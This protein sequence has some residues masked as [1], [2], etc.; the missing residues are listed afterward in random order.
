MTGVRQPEGLSTATDIDHVYDYSE[1]QQL[2]MVGIDVSVEK[3]LATAFGTWYTG[4]LTWIKIL[5]DR[6]LATD[7]DNPSTWAE[8]EF[9][10]MPHVQDTSS[11]SIATGDGFGDEY[12]DTMRD[13]MQQVADSGNDRSLVTD[14]DNSVYWSRGQFYR[15]QGV[16]DTSTKSMATIDEF[17]NVYVE[18]IRNLMQRVE[19]V[20]TK[21]FATV[22]GFD[23]N[24]IDYVKSLMQEVVDP[25]NDRSIATELDSPIFWARDQFALMQRVEDVST[26]SFAN[27][28]GFDELYVNTMRESMQ[29]VIDPGNDR[30]LATDLDNPWWWVIDQRNAMQFNLPGDLDRSLAT[31]LDNEFTWELENRESM[32]WIPQGDDRSLATHFDNLWDWEMR[33]RET[34]EELAKIN[35][36]SLSTSFDNDWHW[37][38]DHQDYMTWMTTDGMDR[39]LATDLDDPFGSREETFNKVEKMTKMQSVSDRSLAT[40]LDNL[41]SWPP[42]MEPGFTKPETTDDRSLATDL[43]AMPPLESVTMNEQ[44]IIAA[45]MKTPDN[46]TDE[47]KRSEMAWVSNETSIFDNIANMQSLTAPEDNMP[48]QYIQTALVDNSVKQSTILNEDLFTKIAESV[49]TRSEATSQDSIDFSYDLHSGDRSLATDLDNAPEISTDN[50]KMVDNSPKNPQMI[51][52]NGTINPDTPVR[53]LIEVYLIDRGKRQEEM[54]EVNLVSVDDKKTKTIL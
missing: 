8:G 35:D 53:D 6:S 26:K 31:D 46:K 40:D 23:S 38:E 43:D 7:L 13:A 19:D 5:D 9:K 39:S 24:Y 3:S 18:S 15:M 16:E 30:S 28:E 25:G 54:Q 2:T 14:L 37:D 32:L 49:S 48:E 22:E 41:A 17:G 44:S 50:T 10:H 51:M 27:S 1:D 12:D 45:Q 47:D 33:T 36:R 20:S 21:S 11:M 42:K 29:E 52:P 34:M 4:E